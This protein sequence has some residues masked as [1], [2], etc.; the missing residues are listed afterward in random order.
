MSVVKCAFCN[1]IGKDPFR[2]LSELSVCQVCSGGGKIEVKGRLIKCAY[3]KGT[4]VYPR[5]SRITCTVC[6]GKG[7]IGF[8][9]DVVFCKNCNG[10]GRKKGESLPCVECRGRGMVE[11]I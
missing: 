10:A 6:G 7:I 1:G 5:S 4:G 8:E 3:C 11:K 9:K 2:L